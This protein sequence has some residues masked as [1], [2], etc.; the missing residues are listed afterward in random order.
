MAI[1]KILFTAHADGIYPKTE[2]Y[3]GTQNE[4]KVTLVRFALSAGLKE[5]LSGALTG[6]EKLMYR[7][8]LYDGAGGYH[9]SDVAELSLEGDIILEKYLHQ[10][11]TE[12][13]GQLALY[14]VISKV[15]EGTAEEDAFNRDF[16]FY[17]APASL[18]LTPLPEVRMEKKVA[19]DLNIIIDNAK[20]ATL[21]ATT[22]AIYADT[23]ADGAIAAAGNA[24]TAAND[25]NDAARSAKKAT[26]DANAA[27]RSAEE[28][29]QKIL[30]DADK[31]VFKGEKGDK[32]DKGDTGAQGKSAYELALLN[33]FEGTEKEWLKSKI[34]PDI[35]NYL[36][37]EINNNEVTITGYK[38]GLPSSVILPDYIDGYPVTSIGNTAFIGCESLTS[39]NIP[40]NITSVSAGAF[41]GCSSL[42][43]INIPASVT[44]IGNG[45]FMGCSSLTSIT[46]PDS[47][48]SIEDSMFYGCTSLTS[49]TIPDSVTSIEMRAFMACTSLTDVYY[50]GSDKADVSIADSYDSNEELNNA[51][52]H[53][54]YSLKGIH[55]T[56]GDINSILAT[57]VEGSAE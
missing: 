20:K 14:L 40:D 15:P 27:A 53:Y 19:T 4:H 52:W 13:G 55:N 22:S 44:S 45:A 54:N 9:P 25:A 10:Y 41:V 12:A 35:V 29:A 32:G 48:T 28:T 37:Y 6:A 31:G 23:A 5:E 7:F 21:G 26:S 51:T 34:N 30:S 8:D 16:I 46:I 47:V 33:G 3:A 43:S 24:I 2:Q 50:G 18:Y 42:T 39:I 17:T 11:E 56:L 49:V 57:V 38:E 1:R 36:E